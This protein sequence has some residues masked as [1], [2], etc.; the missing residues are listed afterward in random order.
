MK[1]L[2]LFERNSEEYLYG[3]IQK[4]RTSVDKRS[5]AMFALITEIQEQLMNL[6]E[7]GERGLKN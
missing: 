1:Q 6:Q 7:K 5:R 3:E 2:E 4:I